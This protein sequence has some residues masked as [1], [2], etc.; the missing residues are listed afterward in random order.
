MGEVMHV[1]QQFEKLP[2]MF[3]VLLEQ[4]PSFQ[5]GCLLEPS[6]S[7]LQCLTYNIFI[8]RNCGCDWTQ[9]FFPTGCILI[10]FLWV[11]TD[12]LGH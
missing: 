3:R 6:D 5:D 2:S 8:S 11:S 9:L 1:S 7:G 10:N 4:V 12:L